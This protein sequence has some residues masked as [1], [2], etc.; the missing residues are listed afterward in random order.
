M[1][2]SVQIQSDD[3]RAFREAS[4]GRDAEKGDGESSV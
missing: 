4:A 2:A 3:S 1:T